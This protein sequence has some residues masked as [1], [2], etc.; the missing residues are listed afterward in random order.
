MCCASSTLVLTPILSTCVIVFETVESSINWCLLLLEEIRTFIL[1]LLEEIRTFIFNEKPPAIL[2]AESLYQVVAVNK[3]GL[4]PPSPPS[5]H[6]MTLREIP[7][8][9]MGKNRIE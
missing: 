5:Y 2:M 7:K 6:M 1:L 9:T 3:V 4:S 8:G